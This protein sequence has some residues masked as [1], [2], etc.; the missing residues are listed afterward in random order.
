MSR[1][2]ARDNA[3]KII[4]EAPFHESE[5]ETVINTFLEAKDFS[6]LKYSNP[7]KR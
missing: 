4:F 6:L 3:F 1:K 7:I 5:L 2:T